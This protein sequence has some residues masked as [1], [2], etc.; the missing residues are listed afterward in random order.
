MPYIHYLDSLV[1]G[2]NSKQ[3]GKNSV[4]ILKDVVSNSTEKVVNI[5]VTFVKPTS[6]EDMEKILKLSTT[7]STTNM[8]L[9]DA[10]GKLHKYHSVHEIIDA[11][12]EVR[13]TTYAK[14]KEKL[15]EQLEQTV[16]KLTNKA[17]YIQLVL[18]GTIDLRRKTQMEIESMLL[19]NGLLKIDQTFDYL[20]KLPMLSVAQE[21][22]DKLLRETD[23]TVR[24]L[25]HLQSTTLSHMYLEDLDLFEGGF[26]RQP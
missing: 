23:E 14:R 11:F 8:H 6:Q 5:H 21:H 13:M 9:F 2:S 10:Q 12:Y 4:P 18:D 26:R 25:H 22:V 15:V 17:K 19:S 24:R 7:V 3:E 20:L 1:D 16:M